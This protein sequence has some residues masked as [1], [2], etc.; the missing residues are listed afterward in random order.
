M[1]LRTLDLGND[2]MIVWGFPKI[3]DTFYGVPLVRTTA[4]GVYLGVPKILGKLPYTKV[5]QDV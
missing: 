1:T 4:Y 2:G 3:R 5:M